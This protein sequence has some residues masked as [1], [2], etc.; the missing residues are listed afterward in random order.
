MSKIQTMEDPVIKKLEKGVLLRMRGIEKTFHQGGK[1][2]TIFKDLSMKLEAGEIVAL[3]GYS[4]SGKSTL[5][6]IAGLLDKPTQGKIRIGDHIVQNLG[7]KDR[8]T[9]R[10][11]MIG[12]IYQ[13]HH[14]LPEFTALENVALPQIIAGKKNKVAKEKAR[15]LLVSLGLEE[16]LTHRPAQLSG[17]EQQRVAIARALAND[18]QI[19]LAD[20]PTGN[21]D[22]ETSAHVFEILLDQ[23]R[24]RNIA[25]LIATHNHALAQ[26]MDRTYMLKNGQLDII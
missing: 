11:D 8:T 15:E 25:A 19:L 22:P 3:V 13:F 6:Q 1:N 4:G 21:L 17:G 9:L 12:F 16:R 5:L 20:E 7:D 2:L 23:V 14:L 18:P 24:K 26:S 10:R